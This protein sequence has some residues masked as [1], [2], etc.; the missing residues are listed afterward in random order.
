M[1]TSTAFFGAWRWLGVLARCGR[2]T[3]LARDRR[4]PALNFADR[5]MWTRDNLDVLRGLNLGLHPIC[6]IGRDLRPDTTRSSMPA[7]T[8]AARWRPGTA[9][10]PDAASD[11][12]GENFP[13]FLVDVQRR[14]RTEVDSGHPEV[15]PARTEVDRNGL[16]RTTCLYSEVYGHSWY[17]RIRTGRS[18]SAVI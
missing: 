9:H 11:A 14:N 7:G 6:G 17:A 18:A 2:R 3:G 15:D 8:T 10:C 16:S 4:D 13:F 5:T 12:V 1:P